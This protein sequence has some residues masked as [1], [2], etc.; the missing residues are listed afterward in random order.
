MKKGQGRGKE[1]AREAHLEQVACALRHGLLHPAA[2]QVQL[3]HQDG[4]PH[5]QHNQ[6][7]VQS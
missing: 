7:D 6:H 1:G 2:V 3:L 5:L 4:L